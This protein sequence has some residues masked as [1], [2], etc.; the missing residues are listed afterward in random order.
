MIDIRWRGKSVRNLKPDEILVF[1]EWAYREIEILRK[2]RDNCRARAVANLQRAHDSYDT[3]AEREMDLGD[4]FER[5]A[6][7][8][9]TTTEEQNDEHR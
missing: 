6:R 9:E 1:A 8:Y 2:E 3:L 5:L 4:K 7:E